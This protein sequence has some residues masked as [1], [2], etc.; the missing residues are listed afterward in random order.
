MRNL[1]TS[2]DDKYHSSYSTKGSCPFM[3]FYDPLQ[4][5]LDIGVVGGSGL[6]SHFSDLTAHIFC[7]SN[8]GLSEKSSEWPQFT[9]PPRG[10]DGL[11]SRS[12]RRT[13]TNPNLTL[14]APSNEL[15][16][17]KLGGTVSASATPLV[18][19]HPQISN[20]S[21]G[22]APSSGHGSPPSML[23]GLNTTTCSVPA[24]PLS[25][26]NSSS[27][28]QNTRNPSPFRY[29]DA[30]RPSH[31]PRIPS[32]NRERRQCWRSSGLAV[33]HPPGSV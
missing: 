19:Q 14:S 33:S 8:T 15:H 10:P 13:V 9:G 5:I 12:D 3:R 20:H 25:V 11:T 18:Q 31:S 29:P 21:L 32:T 16:A 24:T 2:D 23:E 7:E 28:P 1:P 26:P 4:P 17:G 27:S 30:E 22:Q 6:G